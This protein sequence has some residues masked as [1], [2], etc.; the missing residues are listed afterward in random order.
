MAELTITLLSAKSGL[1]E[2]IPSV[3]QT[4]TVAEVISLAQALLGE[5]ANTTQL[6]FNGRPLHPPTMTLQ[7]AGVS[8]G[9][10]LVLQK[11]KPTQPPAPLPTAAATAS[12]GGGGLDFSNLFA[13]APTP[14]ASTSGPPRAVYYPNMNLNEAV[15]H[16]PHPSAIV[17]LLKEKEHLW[18]ELRYH[19]PKLAAS[20]QGEN[21]M[22]KAADLW[23]QNVVQGSI[24]RALERSNEFHAEKRMRD[25][26][27]ANPD[28]VEAKA[29]FSKQTN[30]QKID[31]QYRHVMEEYPESL[32]KVLMLYVSAKINGHEVQAFCDSGAQMTIMSKK[33][34]TACGLLEWV[35]DR[36]AGVATGVGTGKIMGRVHLVQLEF[37]VDGKAYYMPCTITVMDDPPPGASEMP[38]LLGL[39]M[40]KRHLCQID[41]QKG[42]LRFST[43]STPLEVPFLHEKDLDEERGGTKGFDAD[44]QNAMLLEEEDK[45]KKEG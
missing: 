11:P 34:A 14:A 19:N 37:L 2:V 38:F 24:A 44:Q 18:K 31:E 40:M 12:G 3:S 8:S 21:D 4:S 7:Q 20:L 39:D 36:F 33:L 42:V 29:Y 26:L 45:K 13:A 23:R 27:T 22:A 6:L 10:M 30:Q 25:R 28:D 43:G 15:A 41:L 9:D 5:T 16:N 35:D 1:S 17:N 32:S